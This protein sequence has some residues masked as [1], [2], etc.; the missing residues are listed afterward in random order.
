MKVFSFAIVFAVVLATSPLNGAY[1]IYTDK[2]SWISN[3]GGVYQTEDFNDTTLN[4]GIS[5][6]AP[7]GGLTP[8]VFTDHVIRGE[9]VTFWN[10]TGSPVQGVGANWDL[11]PGNPGQ[12][13]Q[14][15]LAYTTEDFE[16]V[17]FE[18]PNNTN[19]GFFGIVSDIPIGS[20][21]I[22]GGTQPHAAL[23][24]DDINGETYTID[25]LVYAPFGGGDPPPLGEIPEPSTMLLT[26]LGLSAAA[27]RVR[28]RP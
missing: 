2:P 26:G 8:P 25:D 15:T 23:P 22:G 16:D 7:M 18:V 13:L 1:L 3:V 21:I 17:R 5:Y 11:M 27:W 10:F 19:G 6:F 12:G 14:I 20:I 9:V 4:P 28:R 24:G